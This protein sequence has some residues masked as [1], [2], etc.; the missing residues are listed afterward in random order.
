[1]DLKQ[2]QASMAIG[3]EQ[4]QKVAA[5]VK[6][7]LRFNGYA[8]TLKTIEKEELKVQ[9]P[10]SADAEDGQVPVNTA[11]VTKSSLDVSKVIEGSILILAGKVSTDSNFI[12]EG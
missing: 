10:G 2:L 9:Q 11:D 12:C 7:F 8:K 5:Q 1:M 4:Y 6:E 3:S